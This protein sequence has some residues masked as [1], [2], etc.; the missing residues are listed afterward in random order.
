TID[1]VAERAGISKATVL[2]LYKSKRALI[3][4]I[5][6]RAVRYDCDFNEAAIQ[7]F[8]SVDGSVVRGRI[9]AAT[10]FHPEASRSVGLDLCAAL[11][12]DPQ[13]GN[14]MQD[15]QNSII[16]RIAKTSA[17]PRGA[18][19]AHLA[20]EGLKLLELLD[21][22]SWSKAERSRLLREI[23]YAFQGTRKSM[24]EGKCG[25]W[26]GSSSLSLFT[27]RECCRRKAAFN[28][29][30]EATKLRRLISSVSISPCFSRAGKR[31]SNMQ[32]GSVTVQRRKRGPEVWC[33]RWREAG[34]DGRKIHRRIVLGTADDLKSLASARKAVVGLRREINLND[35]RI[36]RESITSRWPRARRTGNPL[37][38]GLVSSCTP[39]VDLLY[40]EP[41]G[42]V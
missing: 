38:N 30:F 7:S 21:F 31:G 10:M 5:V 8:G 9:L 41:H 1:A 40:T 28:R 23:E 13:L 6:R 27:T 26:F 25:L 3:E 17:H 16:A 33:F 37:P 36:R 14:P 29:A 19:L 18:L 35:I 2:Y 22:R 15:F 11:A 42:S 34:A 4:A 39:P 32:D 24:R 20:L 12:Q